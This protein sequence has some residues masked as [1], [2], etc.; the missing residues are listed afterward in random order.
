[1]VVAVG[2]RYCCA[3]EVMRFLAVKAHNIF[4]I[5]SWRNQEFS[6]QFTVTHLSV[7]KVHVVILNTWNVRCSLNRI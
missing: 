2:Q 6:M 1:M 5:R 7:I 3:V 4:L